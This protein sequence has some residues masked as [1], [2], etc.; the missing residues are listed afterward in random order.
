MTRWPSMI[1]QWQPRPK[2]VSPTANTLAV[3]AGCS[4]PCALDVLVTWG[5]RGRRIGPGYA[6]GLPATLPL[7]WR[8]SGVTVCLATGA[9]LGASLSGSRLSMEVKLGLCRI[10]RPSPHEIA[11]QKRS[12][13]QCL[14][15]K[16]RAQF[17]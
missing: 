4:P 8:H 6:P 14:R 17:D 15:L 1:W 5:I 11:I 7:P 10:E 2:G 16:I 3:A 9:V 13:D 12:F